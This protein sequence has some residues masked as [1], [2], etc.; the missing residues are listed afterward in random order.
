MK[1]SINQSVYLLTVA[2]RNQ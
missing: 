1:E 2:N